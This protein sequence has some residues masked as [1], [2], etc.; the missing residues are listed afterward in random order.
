[1]PDAS[2]SRHDIVYVVPLSAGV[3]RFQ[4][5]IIGHA[6][7]GSTYLLRRSTHLITIPTRRC[8]R[9]CISPPSEFLL[10]TG[11][12]LETCLSNLKAAALTALELLVFI[13]QNFTGSRDPGHA[14]LSKNF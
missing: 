8:W 4:T 13:A 10:F 1:M 5:V 3:C 11:L 9:D 14:P 7:T 12:S 6:Y 2:T